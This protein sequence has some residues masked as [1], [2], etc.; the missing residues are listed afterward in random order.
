M[1]GKEALL[2]TLSDALKSSGADQ[3]EII[4]ESVH[5]GISRYAGSQLH[6]TTV[7]DDL[8]VGVR[9]VIGQA[10]GQAVGNSLRPEDLAGLIEQATAVARIKEPNPEFVSLAEPESMKAVEG[11]DAETASMSAEGRAEAIGAIVASCAE[12]GWTASGTYLTE[13]RELA[14]VNS[15]G[16]AAHAPSSM[17]FLRA[18]PDSGRGTG[19]ADTLSHRAADLDPIEV[20]QRALAR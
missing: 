10:V 5:Q 11:F 13:G 15:L 14:V 19:Y 8:T 4:V 3:T 7:L 17:A 18:L 9:A 16:V 20:A 6:Q 1:I 2:T 12:R